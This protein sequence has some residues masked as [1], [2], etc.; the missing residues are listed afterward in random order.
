MATNH[1][2]L[3]RER[4]MITGHPLVLSLC[5][6]ADVW[7]RAFE[8]RGCCVVR[9]GDPAFGQPGI[10]SFHPPAGVFDGVLAGIPCQPFSVA[11][12]A[13]REPPSM[14]NLTPEVE[15][16]IG[17]ARPRWWLTENVERAPIPQV[18]GYTVDHRCLYAWE[19]GS[20]QRRKRRFTVGMLTP[21]LILWPLGEQARNPLPTLTGKGLWTSHRIREQRRSLLGRGYT[22]TPW[23]DYVDLTGL[24]ESWDAP[25]LLRTA[26]QLALANAVPLPVARALAE[27]I[28][29]TFY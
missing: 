25:A 21:T 8:E 26:A 27:L 7:S 18:E 3:L 22:S 12:N 2:A 5:P 29:R 17:E 24:P 28:D 9:G 4:P 14:P 19:L 11:R 13:R 10:E 1:G 6:G 20:R 16:V 23:R 15:R